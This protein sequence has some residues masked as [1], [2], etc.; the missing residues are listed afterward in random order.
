MEVPADCTIGAPERLVPEVVAEYPHDPTAFTQGLVFLDGRLFESTG[1]RGRSSVRELDPATGA[2]LR[3][4]PVPDDA[5]AEG[6]AAT[7][8]GRL[9]Q[10]TWTEGVAFVRDPDTLEVVDEFRYG[11]EGWGLTTLTD[12][13]LL[14]SDGTDTLTF[15]DPATF[16]P[17][18]RLVV[19]RADGG[20]D[21]LNELEWDGRHLWAN[22]WQTDE[23]LRIDLRCGTVDGVVDVAELSARIAGMAVPDG[24]A[25]PDGVNG[26]AAVP[27]TDRYLVA[28][29]RWP[30]TFE[31]RFVPA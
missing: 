23:I 12:G 9:V 26:V 2:V 1:L 15:R 30:L 5:F 6:L 11:G 18:G 27:G 28:G 13:I 3:S 20:T 29:K 10:L 22:R 24:A 14:Q 25:A 19:R 17:T 16:D 31:V 21:R 4:A 8:D 7:L